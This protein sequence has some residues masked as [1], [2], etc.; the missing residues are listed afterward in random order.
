MISAERVDAIFKDC[1]TKKSNIDVPIEIKGLSNNYILNSHAVEM[2]SNEIK[3]MIDELRVC[4]GSSFSF[5][6]L[7]ATRDGTQWTRHHQK[8][9]KLMVLGLA[10]NR[11]KYESPREMWP[12]NPGGLPFVVIH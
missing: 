8:V 9:E 7:S 5:F 10:I 1:L 4:T 3:R 6:E 11:L 12:S 2:H